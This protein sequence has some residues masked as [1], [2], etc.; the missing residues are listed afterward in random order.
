MR[1]VLIVFFTAI[2]LLG[3]S[4]LV[5]TDPVAHASDWAEGS[6]GADTFVAPFGGKVVAIRPCLGVGFV[7][8]TIALAP[9]GFPIDVAVYPS[10]FLFYIMSHPGQSVL[11]MRYSAPAFCLTSPNTGFTVPASAWFY[12][13]SI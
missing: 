11:G 9:F 10:P 13:T 4:F 6:T 5:T 3:T 12:G 7:T 1:T 2:L 8:A